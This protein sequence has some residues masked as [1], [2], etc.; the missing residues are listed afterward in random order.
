MQKKTF[1]KAENINIGIGV[2][3]ESRNDIFVGVI[4]YS[5]IQRD[6]NMVMV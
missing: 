3:K 1:Q 5:A 4:C 2:H 6:L